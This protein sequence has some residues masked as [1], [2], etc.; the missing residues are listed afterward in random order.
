MANEFKR[1]I[2]AI[3]QAITDHV[4]INRDKTCLITGWITVIAVS[5]PA[6]P[7]IDNYVVQSSP[8]MGHHAQVGLLNM[9]LDDKRN[10]GIIATLHAMLGDDE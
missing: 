6:L 4:K 10:L 8:G 5:D 9:A 2:N 3:D 7:E 1:T